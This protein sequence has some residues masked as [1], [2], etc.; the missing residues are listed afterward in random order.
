MDGQGLGASAGTRFDYA[1]FVS[2]RRAYGPGVF[3][4]GRRIA[5]VSD[6]LGVPQIVVRLANRLRVYPAIADFLDRHLGAAE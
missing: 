5:F 2:V 3:P 6:L 4:D 1:R